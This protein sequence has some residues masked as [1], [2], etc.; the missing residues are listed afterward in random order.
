MKKNIQTAI[1]LMIVLC[2]SMHAQ[3]FEGT[4]EIK[5][6]T[7]ID[8]SIYVYY[9]S[10]NHVRIDEIG[11]RSN[12][13]EGSFIMDLDAKTI[14]TLNHSRKLYMDQPSP[15]VTEIKGKCEVKKMRSIKNIQGYKCAEYIVTNPE[16]N[17]MISYWIADGKFSFFEKMLRQ[18]NRKDK[19]SIY[20]LQIENIKNMS[21]MLSTQK[22]L[23]G[24]NEVVLEVT[25]IVEKKI[26]PSMFEIPKGY[27]KFDK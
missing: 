12:K 20:Y 11:N 19:S 18:L 27:N 14:K 22:T 16:E 23:D 13:V 25:K 8:T 21:P 6:S 3:S 2:S 9:V 26:V 10:N 4:I 15:A 24:K 5:K 17:T 7:P 1:F